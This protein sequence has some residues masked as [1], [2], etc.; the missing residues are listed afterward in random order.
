MR[1]IAGSAKG[2]RL[3]APQGTDTRPTS[4]KVRESLFSILASRLDDAEVLDLFAGSGALALEALSRGAK[5]AVVNDQSRS[6]LKVIARNVELT[7]FGQDCAIMGN[8]WR[9]ALERLR[10]RRF[11]LVFLDP[12]YR[13]LDCY[14]LSAIQMARLDLLTPDALIVMEHRSSDKLELPK[15]FAVTDERKYGDTTVTFVARRELAV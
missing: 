7:G 12:P 15:M 11:S 8:D 10:G 1:I 9:T 6:A 3:F 4:D 5:S 13:M 2:R 14:S